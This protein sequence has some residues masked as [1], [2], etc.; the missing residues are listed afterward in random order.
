MYSGYQALIFDMDGTV[1]DS[2]P[3]HQKAWEQTLKRHGI[4]Y[5]AQM[6]NH[7]NGWPALQTVEYL[8]E[9]AGITGLDMVAISDEKVALYKTIAPDMV[10]PTPIIKIVKEY[11][12]RRPLALG[13][14]ASTEEATG[15]LE[16]LGIRNYF[17]VIVGADQVSAHKPAPDTFLRCAKRLGFDPE[18]CLV[19]E[20]AEAGFEAAQS[21]HMDYVDVRTLWKG[22]YFS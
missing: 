16:H 17:Q 9:Q 7:L 5:T 20:D 1:I 18:N 8:C 3:A 4:P 15:L 6:M 19:F 11:Y 14:G 12:G 21:A 13:T 2:L 10:K 22:S